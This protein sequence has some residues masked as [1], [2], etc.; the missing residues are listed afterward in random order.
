[1]VA[2]RAYKRVSVNDIVRERLLEAAIEF[3]GAG[4]VVGLDIAKQE[5]VG[6]VR[7]GQAQCAT[8]QWQGRVGLSGDFRWCSQP[9]R[10]QRCSHRG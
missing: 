9:T 5:I 8:R 10:W 7:W 4:T 2:K 3:G 1:M 6:C